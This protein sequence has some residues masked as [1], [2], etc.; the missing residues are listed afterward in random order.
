MDFLE[1]HQKHMESEFWAEEYN[2]S[3]THAIESRYN[4]EIIREW[5]ITEFTIKGDKTLVKWV[6][7]YSPLTDEQLKEK[8]GRDV[9]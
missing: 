2:S 8:Y 1:M 7:R 4:T 6:K 3:V 5:A 9:E